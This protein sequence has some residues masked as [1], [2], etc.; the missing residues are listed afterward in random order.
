MIIEQLMVFARTYA[1]LGTAIQSQAD[2]IVNGDFSDINPNAL[3]LIDRNLRG[4]HDDL[5]A[6]IDQALAA[7]GDT[8]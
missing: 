7:V 3:K 8:Q 4:F 6:Q 1:D 5:D 2:D